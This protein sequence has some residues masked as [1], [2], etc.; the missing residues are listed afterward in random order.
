MENTKNS[1]RAFVIGWPIEHSRSPLI[2]T[3]WL[4]EMNISGSYQAI[5]IELDKVREFLTSA[6]LI[7]KGYIGGN[8]TIPHKE[9][10]FKVCIQC[11]ETARRLRAVNTLWLENGELC[12]DNTDGQGF[13]ANMDDQAQGWDKSGKPAV[14]YGAGGAARAVLLALQGRGF[15][16]LRIINRTPERAR[17][18]IEEL[19][20]DAEVFTTA[21]FPDALRNA[22]LFV[23]TTSLGMIGQPPLEIDIALFD[24]DTVVADIVYAPLLTNLL[25]AARD[26]G[27]TV[28]DGL[29]M[30]LHQAAPGFA[31]W[32]GKMPEVTPALR[33]VILSDLG[34]L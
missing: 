23:N 26:R 24:Q 9:A 33:E 7:S 19:D 28:V 16:E 22:G 27:L 18:M 29:G 11:S 20:I 4:R 14:I 25:G 17:Q 10:A 2:H 8:V 32:F 15:D 5:P 21:Q 3:F 1:P 31:R 13:T 30:L 34:E 6:N 12:G